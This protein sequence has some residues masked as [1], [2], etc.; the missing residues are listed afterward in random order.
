MSL[1]INNNS[2]SLNVL[3]HMRKSQTELVQ[4]LTEVASGLRINRASDDPAG[5]FVSEQLRN[6]EKGVSASK[7]NAAMALSFMQVAEGGLSE[8]TNVLVRM[9]ELAIQA[10]SDTLTDQERGLIDT[11]F[12]QLSSEVDRIARTTR[13]GSSS[14][15]MGSGKA[16]EFQVGADISKENRIIFNLNTN[17]SADELGISSLSITKDDNALEAIGF[18]DAALEQ[19]NASRASFGATQSR[20]QHAFDQQTSLELNLRGARSTIADAD[21]AESFSKMTSARIQT[22]FQIAA[23]AQANLGAES[24][25]KLID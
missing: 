15:L 18:I 12:Q 9:R 16:F 19:V 20:L 3:R 21:I 23:L 1:R 22:D 7:Q 13:Y 11:E 8:Q 14:L 4:S 24:A 17:T 5:F 10:A 25:L 2:L 6:Q